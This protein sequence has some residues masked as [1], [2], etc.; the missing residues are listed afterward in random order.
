VSP[1][2]FDEL[3]G[4]D[5]DPGERERLRR[6]HDLL[7]AAGPPPELPPALR[8]PPGAPPPAE[9]R[10]FPG[11][12]P[13]R[14]LAAAVVLA[15]AIALTAFGAGYLTAEGS[16]PEP[17]FATDFVVPMRGTD[18]AADARAS[19]EV[20]ER[21]EAGNWPMRMTIRNLPA[22]PNL[23]RYE[24]LLT[25]DG[26]LA[27]SCG[28]FTVEGEKT[29][30]FLNAPYRLRQYDTWVITREGSD[31]LL[32]ETVEEEARPETTGEDGRGGAAETGDDDAA[33][34]ET[35]DD[36]GGNSGT[37]GGSDPDEPV[38]N[39]GSGSSGSGSSGGSG[40]NSGS[41]GGSSGSS[42]SNSGSG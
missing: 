30:V 29:V 26:R 5:L 38:D 1:A 31:R 4:A 12:Y 15:A 24:L 2:D 6:T 40:S 20:G 16:D 37:G 27:A 13:R 3:V 41:G 19:L 8:V 17:A 22:L 28:T 21:D 9:V 35:G 23:G 10:M 39:S 42:G 33:A 7:V 18:A 11:G 25:K 32:L 14:R 34:T 36:D